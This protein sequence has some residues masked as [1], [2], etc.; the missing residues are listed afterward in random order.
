[1]IDNVSESLR[2]L[3][4]REALQGTDVEVK[5][6]AP[7]KEWSTRRNAPTLDVFLYDI[8]EDVGR[9]AVGRAD[10]RDGERVIGRV[11]PPR[12]FKLSYLITAWTQRAEDEHRLLSLALGCLIR[13]DA[14]PG[15]VLVGN[16]AGSDV[17]IPYTCVL[18]SQ[19]D[20]ALS[21]TWSAL[22]GEL[23]PSLDLVV[24]SPFDL[25]REVDT[26]PP[27]L[28]PPRITV[29]ADATSSNGDKE[30]K[31]GRRKGPSKTEV[32][33]QPPGDVRAGGDS[34]QRGRVFKVR[35]VER[36]K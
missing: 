28:E 17:K 7:T 3:F 19:Q 20:R 24:I 10:R 31:K 35:E 14:L 32:P 18:P 27:V 15:D 11:E 2:N 23:K 25:G 8:R 1:M 22:G 13:R 12:W 6:D 30:E 29:Q 36:S 9:R 33:E 4:L 5:F 26:G 21:D 34:E 16:L